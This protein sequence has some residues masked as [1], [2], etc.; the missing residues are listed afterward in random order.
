[1]STCKLHEFVL[2]RVVAVCCLFICFVWPHAMAPTIAS[3]Q[4]T[5]DIACLFFRFVVSLF[6]RLFVCLCGLLFVCVSYFFSF[7]SF[8]S[9]F[10]F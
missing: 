8:F 1:M 4:K 6:A 2:V 3:D 10:A 7:V 9:F 5:S